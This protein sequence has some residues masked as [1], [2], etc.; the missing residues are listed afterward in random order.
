MLLVRSKTAAAD[1]KMLREMFAEHSVRQKQSSSAAV[2][3]LAIS[4]RLRERKFLIFVVSG[5]GQSKLLFC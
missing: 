1:M 2:G 4:N 5:F 3:N